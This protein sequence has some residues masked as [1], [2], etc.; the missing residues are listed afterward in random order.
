MNVPDEIC[1]PAKGR[2]IH[3]EEA[4]KAEAIGA[5]IRELRDYRAVNWLGAACLMHAANLTQNPFLKL[6]R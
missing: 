3:P 4:K 6:R 5:L 2:P 1:Q